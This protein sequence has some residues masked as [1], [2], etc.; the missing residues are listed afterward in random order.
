MPSNACSLAAASRLRCGTECGSLPAGAE[1]PAAATPGAIRPALVP[2]EHP[3]VP[4]TLLGAGPGD[5]E[6]LT[7]KA[8]KALRR[9]TVALVDDLVHPGVLR[10]LKRSARVMPSASAA[11]APARRRPSS[12]A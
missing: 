3:P 1:G 12:T 6:L 4:V 5:P 10:Y 7:V 8:V 11:A 2:H 9:A